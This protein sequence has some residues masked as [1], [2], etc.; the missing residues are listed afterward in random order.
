M[1]VILVTSQTLPL[2]AV[3]ARFS[4]IVDRVARQHDRVVVT[5]NGHPAAVLVSLDDL[6]GLEETRAILSDPQLLTEVR[7]GRVAV[8][9]GEVHPL[10]EV[11]ADLGGSPD[12]RA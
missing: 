12:P 7:D 10:D 6:D 4:E 2:A 8:A 5:R 3:K 11:L 9:R 1:T